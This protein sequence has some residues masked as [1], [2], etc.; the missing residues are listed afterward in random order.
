MGKLVP[1]RLPENLGV[2]PKCSGE[3][4]AEEGHRTY[5]CEQLSQPLHGYCCCEPNVDR[6]LPE[7]LINFNKCELRQVSTR[8]LYVFR[9]A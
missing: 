5:N 7:Y 9:A 4:M 6:W 1:L 3:G 2:L 8:I